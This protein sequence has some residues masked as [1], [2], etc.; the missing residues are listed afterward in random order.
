MCY[1]VK[2]QK[3]NKC[4][5]GDLDHQTPTGIQRHR[6]RALFER[7]GQGNTLEQ[8]ERKQFRFKFTAIAGR[9]VRWHALCARDEFKDEFKS[10]WYRGY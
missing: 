1:N 10:G 2:Q 4:V 3:N 6:L 9:A 5:E 8:T 7:E